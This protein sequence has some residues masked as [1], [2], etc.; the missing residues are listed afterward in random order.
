MYVYMLCSSIL[1]FTYHV[2]NEI[3]KSVV[4]KVYDCV[5]CVLLL[6]E[7]GNAGDE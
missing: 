2:G 3:V 7:W 1:L 5:P 4:L 6:E